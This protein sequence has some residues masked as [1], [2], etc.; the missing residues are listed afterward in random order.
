MITK[1]TGDDLLLKIFLPEQIEGQK[2]IWDF[3]EAEEDQ[4]FLKTIYPTILNLRP[5]PFAWSGQLIFNEN[6]TDVKVYWRYLNEPAAKEQSLDMIVIGNSQHA[7][8]QMA[9]TSTN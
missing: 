2:K 5:T 6:A 9:S 1:I 7:V 4:S 3:F 8:T